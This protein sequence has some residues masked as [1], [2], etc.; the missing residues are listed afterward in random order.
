MAAVRRECAG[1]PYRIHKPEGAMFLWLWFEGL[2]LS[3][4]DLYRRLKRRGALVVSGHYFFPGLKEEWRHRQ[5]CVR[6]TYSQNDQD[7]ANGIAIIGRE[8]R[9]AYADSGQ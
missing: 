7:V 3:S 2:P 9:K 4:L 6:V 1:L 5:E 8:V